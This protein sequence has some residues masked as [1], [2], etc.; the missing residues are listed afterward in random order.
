VTPSLKI[1]PVLLRE[2]LAPK[3]VQKGFSMKKR[4]S[5]EQIVAMLR[6]ADVLLGKGM[7]VPE[8]SKQLRMQQHSHLHASINKYVVFD[9]VLRPQDG[10]Q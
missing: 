9:R 3:M 10:A 5:S 6:D 7:K 4:Y 2:S 1:E 8:A